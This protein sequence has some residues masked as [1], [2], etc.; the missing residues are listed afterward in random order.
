MIDAGVEI[1][2]K[3]VRR[4][5][6]GHLELA[7]PIAHIWFFKGIPNR[8][9]LMLDVSPK[10][11]ERVIYFATY[12]VTESS[13]SD[14][15][16]CDILTESELMAAKEKYPNGEF[17][18]E[19][20][21]E[22]LEK[23]LKRINLEEVRQ[24][25]EKELEKASVGKK[26][27]LLKKLDTVESFIKSGNK[28]ESMIKNVIPVI[29]P[30]LRPMVQL[31][32]GRFA[33]SD[34]NDL[35]RRVIN[36]NN[37]LK[38]LMDLNAPEIIVKNEKRMLQESVDALMDNTKRGKPI[39]GA[40]NRPLKSLSDILKGKQGRFRQNL[41]G[42]RVDY[43]GRSVIVVGPELKLYQCGLPR[44][45]AVELFKPFV[46]R[47][48]IANGVA[49][50]DKA[51]KRMV[52]QQRPEIWEYL[53]KVIQ[54]HP[55][56]LNRAP[57]LHRLGIQAFQPVIVE[58]RAIKLHPLT[59][60]AFNADFDGD[61][62]AVHVPLSPEAQA[63]SRYLMLA[64]NNLIKPTDGQPIT[65]PSQDMILGVFYLT[66]EYED[67]IGAGK[68]FKDKEEAFLAYQTKDVT[69][70]SPINVRFRDEKGSKIVKTTVG[71]LIFNEGIPQD[72]GYVDRTIE[73]NRFEP[74]ISFVTKKKNI[75]D[76]IDRCVRIHGIDRT[77]E[78]LD[79][80]KSLGFK[81]STFA[82]FT[83][84]ASDVSVPEEKAKIIKGA[85]KQIDM[86][87]DNYKAGLLSE[88]DRYNETIKVWAKATDD[89]QKAMEASFDLYRNP[90]AMMAHSGARRKYKTF[91]TNCRYAWSYGRYCR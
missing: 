28:P 67:A 39:T 72:L 8:I 16:V 51:A 34:L 77:V 12:I 63:E 20:G 56:L 32:G 75:E 66:L 22:A 42:K 38:R 54:D 45:M 53:D 81:Y 57:T 55:V 40:G 15:K 44:E 17:K 79:F 65:V 6:M 21:A 76:I 91:K 41:L 5:R 2:K 87:V 26:G 71:K 70:Q 14:I 78:L 90:I 52:E 62:M 49:L 84:S 1:T 80:M 19:T 46:M 36:R 82:G 29:P 89:V 88:E 68:Y 33:T 7:A 9:A 73:E 59:C 13:V 27:K 23:L 69:L 61:Q 50:N 3:T 47:E 60:A 31:D 58:G 30:D 86:I 37:R 74:E 35:Y 25:I 48:L 24:K 85:D 43:S 64:T 83:V 11:L 10:A 4:E 18:A